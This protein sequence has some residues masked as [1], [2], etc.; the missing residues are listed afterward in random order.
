MSQIGSQ[1]GKFCV[2]E[3]TNNTSNLLEMVATKIFRKLE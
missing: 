1:Q 3:F 2:A